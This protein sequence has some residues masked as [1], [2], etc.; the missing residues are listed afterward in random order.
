MAHNEPPKEDGPKHAQEQQDAEVPAGAST[1]PGEAET[2]AATPARL[3]GE[4]EAFCAELERFFR[5][6]FGDLPKASEVAELRGQQAA[7]RDMVR[8]AS[9]LGGEGGEKL[10]AM[11][12]ERDKLKESAVRARADF[13]NYQGRAAKDLQRAEEMALRGY[14]L[15]MLPVLD[16]VILAQQDADK[17]ASS[18]EGQR[19]SHAIGMIYN[20]LSQTLAVRGL[21]RITVA[22][23][24]PFDPNRHEAVALR[25]ADSAKGEKPG[26]VLEELRAGYLW[27]E[28]VLRPAQVLAA[29]PEKQ[30]KK[31]KS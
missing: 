2:P 28:L 31:G 18:P 26:S 19:L 25:P 4:A 24:D 7:V 9:V 3:A 5:G 10:I 6:A 17:S 21:Q 11:T 15:E 29:E 8:R 22:V 12:A 16:S 20:S 1:A 30:G 23:G 13:L 14:M 27:K